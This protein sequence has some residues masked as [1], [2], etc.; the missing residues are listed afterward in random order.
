MILPPH[1]CRCA[2]NQ[3]AEHLRFQRREFDWVSLHHDLAPIACKIQVVASGNA[4]RAGI[5]QS[6]YPLDYVAS[7]DLKHH[8]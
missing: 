4:A 8:G 5:N 2:I 7:G 1:H 6:R 3:F